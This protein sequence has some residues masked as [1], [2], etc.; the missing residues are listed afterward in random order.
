[1]NLKHVILHELKKEKNQSGDTHLRK[2]VLKI[3]D[4]VKYLIKEIL[5]LYKKKLGKGFGVFESDVALFPFQTMLK[6]SLGSGLS[7]DE[8][9]FISFSRRAMDILLA[10]ANDQRFSTGGYVLFSLYVDEVDDVSLIVAMLRNTI[11][12]SITNSLDVKESIHIDLSKLHV[13][14]Q[15]DISTWMSDTEEDTQYMSFVKGRADATT[16]DYFLKFV[17]CSEFSDS[18][19]QTESLRQIV[20]DFSA[21]KGYSAEQQIQLRQSVHDYCKAKAD[22]GEKVYL[23]DLSHHLNEEAP[24]E[25]IEFVNSKEYSISNGFEVNTRTLR[26]MKRIQGGNKQLSISFDSDLYGSRVLLKSQGENVTFHAKTLVIKDPPVSVIK[27]IEELSS[28]AN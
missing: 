14:C 24:D 16:P 23:T 22:S 28:H 9:K 6:T 21:E 8:N 27:S 20:I 3:T 4:P 1:M 17:G 11:G 18:K 15:I 5:K 13:C 25:F 26:T 2:E 10:K 19:R 12:S 7:M